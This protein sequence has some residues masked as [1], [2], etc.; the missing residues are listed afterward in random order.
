MNILNRKR[1]NTAA[2]ALTA[3]KNYFYISNR[4]GAPV[5]DEIPDKA[6]DKRDN[7]N[8]VYGY[9]AF[10]FEYLFVVFNKVS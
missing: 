5:L 7:A 6:A 10:E 3:A 1:K 4:V 8:N 2:K 9:Q